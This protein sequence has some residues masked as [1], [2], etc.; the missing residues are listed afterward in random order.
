MGETKM[1][2]SIKELFKVSKES[3]KEI[4]LWLIGGFLLLITTEFWLRGKWKYVK[5][6]FLNKT[7]VFFVNYFLILMITS[8]IFLVKRKKTFYFLTSVIILTISAIS[9]Y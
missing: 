9:K 1:E 7:G 5:L 3:I 8:L 6:L 2:N 4:L